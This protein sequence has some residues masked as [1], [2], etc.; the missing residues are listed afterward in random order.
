[1]TTTSI[2]TAPAGGELRLGSG[3]GWHFLGGSW[4]EDDQGVIRPPEVAIAGFGR[5]QDA[6]V[7]LDGQPAVRPILPMVIAMDHRVNDG[8]QLGAFV[9]TLTAYLSDPIRLLAAP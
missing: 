1:M 4:R 6:V 3:D 9:A 5:I 2:A 7:A 8:E